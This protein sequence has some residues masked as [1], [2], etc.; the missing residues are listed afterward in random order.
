MAGNVPKL[1]ELKANEDE[2]MQLSR[3]LSKQGQTAR[4]NG[5]QGAIF[6]SITEL[7]Y[8]PLQTA[9]WAER[10]SGGLEKGYVGAMN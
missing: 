5:L 4:K 7:L 3:A 9:L 2:V 10:D 6:P 1:D 8:K